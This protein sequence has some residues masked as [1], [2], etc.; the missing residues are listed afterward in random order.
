MFGRHEIHLDR[1]SRIAQAANEHTSSSTA[2]I[3]ADRQRSIH[4]GCVN[5]REETADIVTVKLGAFE[6]T[7]DRTDLDVACIRAFQSVDARSAAIIST[8]EQKAAAE[9]AASANDYNLAATLDPSVLVDVLVQAVF[10]IM[11]QR[12]EAADLQALIESA[13]D[14]AKQARVQGFNNGMQAAKAELR[15][16]LGRLQ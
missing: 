9:A 7:V 11:A 14:L 1:L 10:E 15:T 4:E 6:I 3:T 2:L 13:R 12:L 8:T 5:Y 16:W